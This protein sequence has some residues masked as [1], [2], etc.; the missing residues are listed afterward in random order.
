[1][2][3]GKIKKITSK[4]LTAMKSRGEKIAMLTAYDFTTASIMDEAGIDVLLVGDSASNVM[5]GEQY[6]LPMSVEHMIV[7][8]RNVARAC[9]RAHVVVDMPFGSYQIGKKEAVENAIRI[10]KETG[11]DSLKLEGGEEYA[12]VIAGIIRAGIPVCGHLGLTPQSVKAFGGY[13]LRANEKAEADRLL[14]DVKILENTGCYA[15]V[16]EKVPAEIGQRAAASVKIPIIGIGAGNATDGQV[17]V[18][19]DMLGTTPSF[20]P[21]FV[22][23]YANL[24]DVI[25]NA[26]KAYSADVKSQNFPSAEE[27]Y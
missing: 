13:G 2:A 25:G 27:S 15:I 9:K 11:C 5:E 14:H 6:T 21:K 17:L 3:E 18:G 1:M 24:H 10:V 22:R 19:Q 26:V 4:E 8:G 7:Y 23:Q 20:L 16:I 12:D